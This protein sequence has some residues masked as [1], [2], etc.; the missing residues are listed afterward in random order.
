MAHDNDRLALGASAQRTQ[1]GRL[2]KRIE[3]ARGLVQQQKRCP[4]QKRPG[5]PHTLALAIRK[6]APL[7]AYARVQTLRQARSKLIERGGL[8][9][10]FQLFIASRRLCHQQVA[11]QATVK[12]IGLLRHIGHKATQRRDLKAA[13][14]D[15]INVHTAF[16]GVIK[17]HHELQQG[18]LSCPA[19]ASNAHKLPCLKTKADVVQDLHT[20]VRKAQIAHLKALKAADVKRIGHIAYLVKLEHIE[21][22]VCSG[23]RLMQRE[24]QRGDIDHGA[25]ARHE[26]DS[27]H[28][29]Q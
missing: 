24:T 21:H 20:I 9:G 5:K 13:Q 12:K 23:K 22:L 16:A 27:T 29:S 15:A 1:D 3:V 11:T 7:A 17:T 25:H 14:V 10:S 2:V 6:A 8:N 28:R 26:G 4:A 19:F 18:R